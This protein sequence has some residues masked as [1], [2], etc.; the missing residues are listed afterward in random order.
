MI[1]IFILKSITTSMSIFFRIYNK[2]MY[3]PMKIF[4]LAYAE[5]L[6]SIKGL[7]HFEGLIYAKGT[8][9]IIINKGC[10]ISK[11]L[12]LE[13][14]ENGIIEIGQNV[15]INRF[16]TIVSYSSI[17]IGSNTLIGEFVSIRDAN[18]GIKKGQ[19]VRDQ[20]HESQPISIG[21]DVWIGRGSVI[22]PG[23]NIGK[24]CIIGAN[25]VVTK[26]IPNFQIAVGS[27]AKILRER[28]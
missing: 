18:H 25:S 28:N 2:V 12:E 8:K 4:Y 21:E 19:N 13:T 23:V 10:R 26:S 6:I 16:A 20:N 11:G 7:S 15:R 22:L 14:N 5:S 1:K 24:G 3:L 27:P 9:N 17:S